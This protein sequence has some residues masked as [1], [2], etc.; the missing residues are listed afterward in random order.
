MNILYLVSAAISIAL[1]IAFFTTRRM[2]KKISNST[3]AILYELRDIKKQLNNVK[4]N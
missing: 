3:W 1:I 2:I 4:K